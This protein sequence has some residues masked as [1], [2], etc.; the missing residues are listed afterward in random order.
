MH[1]IS[2]SGIVFHESMDY[3]LIGIENGKYTPIKFI[4]DESRKYHPVIHIIDSFEKR[5]NKHLTCWDNFINYNEC[6]Y[7]TLYTNLENI[8][9]DDNSDII[10]LDDIN[11]IECVPEL[12]WLIYMA[13][14]SNIRNK[15]I[16][17]L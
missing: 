11:N 6:E 13:M 8:E 2:V 1:Q 10:H 16:V 4:M 7:Y 14:D 9:C 3:V 17:S 12:K 15:S 5:F